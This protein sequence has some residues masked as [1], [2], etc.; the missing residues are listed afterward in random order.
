MELVQHRISRRM[1]CFHRSAINNSWTFYTVYFRS[2]QPLPATAAF[3]FL[4]G[5]QTRNVW[6]DGVVLSQAPTAVYRRDFTNRSRAV[7]QDGEPADD[8][9]GARFSTV[10]AALRRLM[11]Q[12]IVERFERGLQRHGLLEHCHLRP[13]VIRRQEGGER[14]PAGL[15]IAWNR[16]ALQQLNSGSQNRAME[17]STSRQMEHIR[18]RPGCRRRRRWDLEHQSPSTRMRFPNGAT[19]LDT[20]SIDQTTAAGGDQWH[21]I[22]TL[23]LTAAGSPHVVL[24]NGGSGSLIADAVPRCTSAALYNDGSPAPQVTLPPFDGILLQRQYL[25]PGTKPRCQIPS[26]MQPATHRPLHPAVSFRSSEPVWPDSSRSWTSA[27]FSG[28]NLPG[29]YSMEFHRRWSMR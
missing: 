23:N 10:P 27:D 26:G 9:G 11:C 29:L 5:D 19:V 18:S 20:V 12:Y 15:T 8:S 16:C 6:I 3:Q 13:R 25:H 14:F 21:T 7:E 17:S 4:M 22:A 28:A 24:S 1:A 2:D